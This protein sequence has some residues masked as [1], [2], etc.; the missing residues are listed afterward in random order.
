MQ[1]FRCS[2]R[3]SSRRG[4]N[5]YVG[6]QRNPI[7]LQVHN[8][9]C[10]GLRDEASCLVLCRV[11]TI[12][13]RFS[14]PPA[15]ASAGLLGAL[16]GNSEP[17]KQ[18][19]QRCFPWRLQVFTHSYKGGL[20]SL[21]EAFRLSTMGTD[22]FRAN[23]LRVKRHPKDA[24]ELVCSQVG[25]RADYHSI[26]LGRDNELRRSKIATDLA[27]LSRPTLDGGHGFPP[28]NPMVIRHNSLFRTEFKGTTILPTSLETCHDQRCWC[29]DS[30]SPTNFGLGT[31][32][33]LIRS[34]TALS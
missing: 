23:G 10:D 6:R 34:T 19:V 29:N 26:I 28:T 8:S 1:P 22:W 13:K 9:S 30:F 32:P 18:T 14:A 21:P 27:P 4:Q 12:D 17:I 7:L 2:G 16:R 24:S 20:Q 15:F 3:S 11:Q 25:Q 5:H 33:S 31:E